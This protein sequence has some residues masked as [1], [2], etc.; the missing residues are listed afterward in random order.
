MVNSRSD[1]VFLFLNTYK[2][3]THPRVIYLDSTSDMYFKTKFINTCDAMLH[4]RMQGESFGLSVLEFACKNK[5]IITYGLSPEKSH[6]MYLKDNC[7]VY[8][9]QNNLDQILNNINKKNPYNTCYLNEMFSPC[10]VMDKFKK[11]FLQ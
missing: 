10:N 4:A 8:Y 2:F 3:I 1:I 11:V 9:N 5:H 7:S 6:I